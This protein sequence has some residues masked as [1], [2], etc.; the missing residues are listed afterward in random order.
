[1]IE[2]G[3]SSLTNQELFTLGLRVD[4]I[5]GKFDAA[6]LGFL[7]Y[8][9][10]FKAQLAEYKISIEKQ[11]VSAEELAAKDKLRDNYFIALR[12]H[13]RNFRYHPDK[14]RKR[15]SKELL[16]VLNRKGTKIYEASYKV[17][18][19]AF[20]TMILTMEKALIS[21]IQNLGATEWFQLFK[22][23]QDD[24]E[25]S[26]QKVSGKKAVN[27]EVISATEKRDEFENAIEKLF[28]FL[29]LHYEATKSEEL[30][31]LIAE[32]QELVERF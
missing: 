17:E 31:K 22:D 4:K 24:F 18:T 10:L 11:Q 7:F 29:P 30:R 15:E 9:N 32:L 3:L 25:T 28:A 12:N 8:T 16:K 27:K 21:M 26:I 2:I 6:V 13:I 14:E 1:M 19:A 5:I 20:E 23:A